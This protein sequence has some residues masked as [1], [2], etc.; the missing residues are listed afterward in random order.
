M[1]VDKFI[2]WSM[3]MNRVVDSNPGANSHARAA[4]TRTK[5]WQR[6]PEHATQVRARGGAVRARGGVSAAK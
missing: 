3:S 6:I 2:H 5:S 1:Y 4:R